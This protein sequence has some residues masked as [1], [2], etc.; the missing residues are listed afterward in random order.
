MSDEAPG[1]FGVTLELAVRDRPHGCGIN[2]A[3]DPVQEPGYR[4]SATSV[5]VTVSDP[6]GSANVTAHVLRQKL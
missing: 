6:D 5:I 2:P 4:V 1:Q 3:T